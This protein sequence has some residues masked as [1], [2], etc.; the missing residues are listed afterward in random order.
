MDG[1]IANDGAFFHVPMPMKLRPL[2]MS[3]AIYISL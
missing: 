2:R 3:R 1:S